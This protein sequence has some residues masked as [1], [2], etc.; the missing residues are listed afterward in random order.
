M[1][2]KIE[3]NKLIVKDGELDI[4][5]II[6][7]IHHLKTCAKNKTLLCYPGNDVCIALTKYSN[8]FKFND[9]FIDLDE[10]VRAVNKIKMRV[11]PYKHIS[12]K[13][14]KIDILNNF[15]YSTNMFGNVKYYI[16]DDYIYFDKIP[17]LDLYSR[18]FTKISIKDMYDIVY[19][20]KVYKKYYYNPIT[21]LIM[22][23]NY[24]F[25]VKRK[26]FNMI[27]IKEVKGVSS[28]STTTQIQSM[29]DLL[30]SYTLNKNYKQY[31]E[32]KAPQCLNRKVGFYIKSY[33]EEFLFG[34][35]LFT[36]NTAY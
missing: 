1:N 20:Q 13:D 25:K 27:K 33:I 28:G 21:R 30:N 2:F 31:I 16:E 24:Y 35:P 6:K 5:Y 19:N 12:L 32:A 4:N 34:F 9:V 36:L 8:H 17:I 3:N 18:D 14:N 7:K 26:E 22:G 15:I 10:F 23:N 29:I 11:D